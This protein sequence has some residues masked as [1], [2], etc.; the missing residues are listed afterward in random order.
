MATMPTEKKHHPFHVIVGLIWIGFILI[1]MA[2]ARGFVLMKLWEWFI[3]PEFMVPMLTIYTATAIGLIIKFLTSNF[4]YE[5][6]FDE[7]PF[8]SVVIFLFI[9]GSALTLGWII[10]WFM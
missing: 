9:N 8:D 4:S 5:Q 10:T 6:L 2:F 7:D 1:A 3:F